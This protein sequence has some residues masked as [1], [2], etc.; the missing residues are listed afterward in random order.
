MPYHILVVDDDSGFREEFREAL[1]DYEIVEASNGNEAIE[2]LKKPNE[3][4]IVLL[5]VMMPGSRGTDVLRQI[6]QIN[7]NLSTIIITG[8]SSTDVAVEALKG[9]ADDYIEKPI[10]IEKTRKII[11]KHLKD[12]DDG[13][14]IDS[15]DIKGKVDRAKLFA[16]R[17]FEKKVT[18]EDAAKTVGLSPKYLSRIFKSETGTGFSEYRIDLKIRE[19]K[20]MLEQT[21]YNINQISDKLGY[22]NVESFI[23]AFKKITGTTPSDFRKKK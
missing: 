22:E 3:I 21:G 11:A 17:N 1:D 7:P 16:E 2:I 18:L 19:A 4:D 20:K 15:L 14:G 5:D 23:R 13:T 9:R 8:Y 12:K 6:K 10:D